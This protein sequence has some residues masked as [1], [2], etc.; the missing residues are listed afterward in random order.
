MQMQITITF[1]KMGDNHGCKNSITG[2]TLQGQH[3]NVNK[4]HSLNP[5]IESGECLGSWMT[6]AKQS[7]GYLYGPACDRNS[8]QV[9][10]PCELN[11][12][13]VGCACISCRAV[14]RDSSRDKCVVDRNHLFDDH[15]RYHHARHMDCEFC[16]QLF[17]A[18]PCFNYMGY[19]CGLFLFSK[20]ENHTMY[21]MQHTEKLYAFK[22]SRK[23]QFK[24]DE[25]NLTFKKAADKMRHDKA[26][27]YEETNTCVLCSKVF[28]RRDNFERHCRVVH[29]DDNQGELKCNICKSIFSNMFNLKRHNE[30]NVCQI[31]QTG[32][33][34]KRHLKLHITK[35]HQKPFNC[36]AC[37]AAFSRRSV[38]I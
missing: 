15:Q 27:H 9:F 29:E 31:C 25:C 24:C 37:G 19:V 34:S 2:R 32:F 18:F 7:P 36:E 8:R 28:N 22:P 23:V 12:C 35:C 17:Q 11:K 4:C 21:V 6:T 5:S 30:A 38:L 14:T 3:E 10:Y 20:N 13:Y 26:I 16:S 33:C 1:M